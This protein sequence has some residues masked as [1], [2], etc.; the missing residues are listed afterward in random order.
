MLLSQLPSKFELDV[1]EGALGASN[2][3]RLLVDL[4]EGE[5]VL[6]DVEAVLELQ[7][8]QEEL[9]EGRAVVAEIREILRLTQ[10]ARF[11]TVPALT[12]GEAEAELR[13]KDDEIDRAEAR[14]RG[15]C[16][17]V[18]LLVLHS[19]PVR[20][21]SGDGVS[22][23]RQQ[24]LAWLEDRSEQTPALRTL[25]NSGLG[26]PRHRRRYA[27]LLAEA[28]PCMPAW[29]PQLHYRG[30]GP[31]CSCC[32]VGPPACRLVAACAHCEMWGL[33][34]AAQRSSVVAYGWQ[35]FLLRD[36]TAPSKYPAHV[37]E[38]AVALVLSTR[39]VS[40]DADVYRAVACAVF[41]LRKGGPGL[42]PP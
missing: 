28:A 12:G 29:T 31:Q 33:L 2:E 34:S 35:L 13:A 37:K 36:D 15:S 7:D 32:G 20:R 1:C 9:E 16:E 10:Y 41:I 5:R 22:L 8:A 3:E 11:L 6:C 18:M 23:Y 26:A 4:R 21:D 40:V 19:L 27:R 42:Y 24:C 30:C 25:F 14:L 38:I 39:S 17:D